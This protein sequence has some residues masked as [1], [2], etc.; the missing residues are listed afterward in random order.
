[1]ARLVTT[2]FNSANWATE[3]WTTWGTGQ[4]FDSGTTHEG[5][6]SYKLTP[7][8]L[9]YG[10]VY[11]NPTSNA[12]PMYMR[13]YIRFSSFPSTNA[14]EIAELYFGGSSPAQGVIAY[15]TTGGV[16][17]L[18][19]LDNVTRTLRLTGSNAM[20][21]NTWYKVELGG[22]ANTTGGWAEVKCNGD[23]LNY[24][25][26]PGTTSNFT[27]C[28]LG[29]NEFISGQYTAFYDDFA[30]NDSTTGSDNSYPASINEGSSYT[31]HLLTLLGVGG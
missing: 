11:R 25:W 13:F 17:A 21:L 31:P 5:A 30:L 19:T 12:N 29:T 6:N 15:V 9:S 3:G 8:S 27:Q 24:S 20:S 16:I 2:D 23:T 22:Y 1:M 18:Y 10:M 26:T 4:S 14:R 28:S 7:P